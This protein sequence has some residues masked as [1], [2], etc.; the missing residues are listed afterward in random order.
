[1]RISDWSSDVC[2]SDLAAGEHELAQKRTQ[3]A[4][5]EAAVA[6]LHRHRQV[7]G[8]EAGAGGDVEPEGLA[9]ADG[10]DLAEPLE[11]PDAGVD[12]DRDIDS[13]DGETAEQADR[14]STRLNSSP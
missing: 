11:Q 4:A 5:Q 12:G 1:M 2:S 8:V 7:D 10:V 13:A 9:A 6:E 14:K 3:E